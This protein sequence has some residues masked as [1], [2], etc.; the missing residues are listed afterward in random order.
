MDIKK[1]LGHF[2]DGSIYNIKHV[3]Q[4]MILIMKSAQMDEEDLVDDAILSKDDRILGKLHIEGIKKITLNHN[5]YSDNFNMFY[6]S[7]G[8]FD[9]EMDQG[10]VKLLI[11]WTTYRPNPPMDDF[12]VVEIEAE[13]IWW[14]NLPDLIY[15]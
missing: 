4:E 12:S 3:G 11:S 14:E 15:S 13:N 9:F 7:A 2:H 10:N 1:Y 5:V 8:I 6:E